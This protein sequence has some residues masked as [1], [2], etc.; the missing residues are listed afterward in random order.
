MSLKWD[1]NTFLPKLSDEEKAMAD[2]CLRKF[3]QKMHDAG[4]L[5]ELAKRCKE[6]MVRHKGTPEGD[7]AAMELVAT[8]LSSYD[9]PDPDSGVVFTRAGN[10]VQWMEWDTFRSAQFEAII[11]STT[12]TAK[13]S[14]GKGNTRVLENL[15]Y[16]EAMDELYIWFRAVD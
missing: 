16:E 7:S 2:E 5:E 6:A 1:A 12:P 13:V 8:L 15:S 14:L 3:E 11:S 9:L 10:L 4:S